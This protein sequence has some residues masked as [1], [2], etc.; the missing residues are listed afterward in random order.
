MFCTQCGAQ[1]PDTAKFCFSCGATLPVDGIAPPQSVPAAPPPP[2]PA[3]PPIHYAGFW[4]RFVALIIDQL[5]LAVPRWIIGLFFG[6]SV[7]STILSMGD[8]FDPAIL[9]GIIANAIWVAVITGILQWLYYALFESSAMQA[10]PG[11][12]ALGI[13]VT[14]MD[15]Q[16][17]SFM[18]ASGRFFGKIISGLILC[19]GYIMAG[20]TPKKQALHDI[21]ADCL[22]VTKY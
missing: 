3:A 7:L 6:V 17:I 14:D 9:F 16:Q 18:R 2:V 5:I 11:K 8:N 20:F 1:N 13:I 4:R 10:T 19:I 22:V 15:H 21:M 12:M